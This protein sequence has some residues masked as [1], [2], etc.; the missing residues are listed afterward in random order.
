M[1]TGLSTLITT[2]LLVLPSLHTDGL[3]ATWANATSEA[4]FRTQYLD[5]GFGENALCSRIVAMGVPMSGFHGGCKADASRWIA[6][7]GFVFRPNLMSRS[8]CCIR[9]QKGRS[10]NSGPY[11]T[12]GRGDRN[13]DFLECFY[14]NKAEKEQ[15]LQM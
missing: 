2:L 4:K 8:T 10:L 15:H 5:G 11:D 9:C 12:I 13:T 1:S 6:Q 3:L 7:P 14:C